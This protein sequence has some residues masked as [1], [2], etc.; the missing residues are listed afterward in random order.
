MLFWGTRHP[1]RPTLPSVIRPA[2]YG[3]GWVRYGGRMGCTGH[4]YH[5]VHMTDGG[6]PIPS[7]THDGWGV[8]QDPSVS[9]I[10]TRI[11]PLYIFAG[12]IEKNS[13]K[14]KK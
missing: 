4:L 5:V 9:V 14:T 7:D 10:R 11:G 2:G 6:V 1:S 8:S 13:R 12:G 3:D